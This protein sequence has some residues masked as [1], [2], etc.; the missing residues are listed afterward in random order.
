M[1]MALGRGVFEPGTRFVR[2]A[3]DQPPVVIGGDGKL[4]REN[5]FVAPRGA[6]YNFVSGELQI[7]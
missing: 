2:L 6:V 4:I 3:G 7:L 5:L 1:D